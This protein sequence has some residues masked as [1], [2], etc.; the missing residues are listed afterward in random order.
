MAKYF[1]SYFGDSEGNYFVGHTVVTASRE[2]L[3]QNV[4]EKISEKLKE[5]Y[6][7]NQIALLNINRLEDDE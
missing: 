2:E 1:V 4:L 5:D 3:T 7:C 6:K